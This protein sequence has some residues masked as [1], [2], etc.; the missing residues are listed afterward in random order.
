MPDDQFR[1]GASAAPREIINENEKI[2][3]RHDLTRSAQRV[4]GGICL[5]NDYATVIVLTLVDRRE[6]FREAVFL[7]RIP[8]DAAL[9]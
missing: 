4:G 2:I 6:I 1:D 9:S 5:M 7:C 3:P 8:C